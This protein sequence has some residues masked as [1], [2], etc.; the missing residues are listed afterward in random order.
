MRDFPRHILIHTTLYLR[1][2]ILFLVPGQ[3]SL[4]SRSFWCLANNRLM[5]VTVVVL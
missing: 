1:V 5:D 4:Y 2:V 3:A